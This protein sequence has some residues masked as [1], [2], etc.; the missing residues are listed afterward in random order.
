[1]AINNPVLTNSAQQVSSPDV[2][3]NNVIQAGINM[4]LIIGVLYFLF[5]LV[6]SAFKMM[7][8]NGD[9]KKAEEAKSSLTSSIIGLIIA[10]S[11]FAILKLIGTI[12]GIAGL[13][14]LTISWPHL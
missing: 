12:F 5:Q 1:M 11:I 4:L 7:S 2:Y 6:M 13:E 8:S 3:I 9:A 10:F 14:S